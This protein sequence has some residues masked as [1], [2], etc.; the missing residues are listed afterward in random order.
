MIKKIYEKPQ[1]KVVNQELVSLICSTS[2][3]TQIRVSIDE[4]ME[5]DEDFE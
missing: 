2:S 1:L 3:P 4:V 5:E